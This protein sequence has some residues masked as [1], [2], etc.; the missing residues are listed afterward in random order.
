MRPATEQKCR[1]AKSSPAAQQVTRFKGNRRSGRPGAPLSSGTPTARLSLGGRTD[2]CTMRLVA[3]GLRSGSPAWP[4]G[5][6][7][8]PLLWGGGERGR[9][10]LPMCCLLSIE[11][12]GRVSVCTAIPWYPSLPAI[13]PSI[14]VCVCLPFPPP[15]S[16]SLHLSSSCHLI[17]ICPS[18][19]LSDF[20][21]S[22]QHQ[23]VWSPRSCSTKLEEGPQRSSGSLQPFPC[24]KYSKNSSRIR[25]SQ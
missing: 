25:V 24:L 14:P 23:V 19:C 17:P 16:S 20:R 11:P 9:S 13:P 10:N 21:V 7:S 18:T 2:P 3:A 15:N 12:V 6:P 5:S 4:Q 8:S 22:Y 1:P